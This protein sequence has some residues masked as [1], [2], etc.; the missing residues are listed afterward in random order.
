MS[1][2]KAI[3]LRVEGKPKESLD[4][5]KA[6][7]KSEPKNPILYYQAAWSCDS[8]GAEGEAVVFYEA[9][10]GNGL[11]GEDLRGALLGLG[12]TYRCLGRYKESFDTFNKA[13]SLFPEDRSFQVFRAL[14]L[15]NLGEVEKSTEAL[16]L[17]LLETTND[18]NILNYEK[19]LRFYSDKLN[20]TWE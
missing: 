7:L 4:V 16:L 17:N 1:L 3:Q 15:F 5:I 20:E 12:S 10:I 9:A 6:L 18:K 13:I 8:M 11:V 14:T 19:A 2:E